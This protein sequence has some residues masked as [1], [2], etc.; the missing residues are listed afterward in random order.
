MTVVPKDAAPTGSLIADDELL[1]RDGHLGGVMWFTGL[2][3]SGKSTLAAALE[4]RLFEAGYHVGALDGDNLRHGLSSDLGFSDDDRAENIRRVGEVAALFAAGGMVVVTAFISPFQAD[5]RLARRAAGDGFHEIF[6]DP[7][8]EV[9]ERRDPKGLYKKAR[10]G[11]IAEFTGISS[12]YEE[13]QSPELVIDTGVLDVDE[14]LER[15]VEYAN[16]AF[17]A[18]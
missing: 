16:R 5:R 12:P 4:Q 14:C 17:R 7:G 13:P 3:G 15:L 1:S 6:L 18:P 10:A 9:C 11:E 8:L 2:S